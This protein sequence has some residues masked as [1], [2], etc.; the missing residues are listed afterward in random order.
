MKKKVLD[1]IGMVIIIATI[2]TFSLVIGAN[3]KGLRI[4]PMSIILGSTIIYLVLKKVLL[5]QKIVIKNKIDIFAMLFF[6]V[7]FLPL[8]FGTYCSFD[9]TIEFILKYFF[10]YS[11]YLLIRNTVD[12]NKK[13]SIVII[14]TLISSL[15]IV[16]CGIDIENG[17]YLRPILKKINVLYTPD[18]RF[19]ST[20][21]YANT[22][23]IYFSFCVFLAIRQIQNS[24]KIIPKIIYLLY[25]FIALFTIYKAVS[26]AVFALLLVALFVYLVIRFSSNIAKYNKKISKK[27]KIIVLISILVLIAAIIFILNF[28][29]PYIVTDSEYIKSFNYEFN[30]DEQYKVTLELEAT[31]P[32]GYESFVVSINETNNYFQTKQMAV[33]KVDTESAKV[34]LVFKPSKDFYRIKLI[35]NNP[36][37]QKVTINKCYI[38]GE[39]YILNY[40]FLPTKISEILT[41]MSLNDESVKQRLDFWSTS[42]KI[43]KDSPLIGQGGNAWKKLSR[44]VQDYPYNMKETHSYFFELLISYG[45][46]GVIL[47][48]LLIVMFCI[49]LIKNFC[50]NKEEIKNKLPIFIGLLLIILHSLTFDFDMSFVIILITVFGYMALLMYDEKEEEK[51]EKLKYIDFAI[52]PL[53]VLILVVY[54]LAD[55]ARYGT[56]DIH[57]RS[58]L[59]FYNSGVQYDSIYVDIFNELDYKNILSRLQMLMNREPYYNQS[60]VYKEYWKA[61]LNH[62]DD[63]KEDEVISYVQFIIDKYNNVKF[64]Q[65]MYVNNILERVKP[66]KESIVKLSSLNTN[67][68]ELSSQVEELKEIM[69]KEYQENMVNIKAIEK[70]GIDETTMNSIIDEYNTI[71]TEIM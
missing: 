31:K 38:N 9:S 11:I 19:S 65:P 17:Q 22:V 45:V 8:I 1:I 15:I 51:L 3:E 10:V 47:Y 56:K 5:H 18:T 39:E 35:V 7:T 63:L 4:L 28:S 43:A 30:A 41:R 66:M 70:T 57:K 71:M 60:N 32:K 40:K 37:N 16:I 50:K 52:I 29:K 68:K 27:V 20:F 26:R 24:N 54:I 33:Q 23:A 14:A 64:D 21:G 67:N 61:I 69:K 6:F 36:F 55:M 58:K 44:S 13:V 42:I 46:I 48:L 2:A 59:W 53:F 12:S 62:L 25:I 34:E 49:K